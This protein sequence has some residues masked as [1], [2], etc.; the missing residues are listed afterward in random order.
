MTICYVVSNL[1]A[2]WTAHFDTVPMDTGN[3]WESPSQ[4]ETGTMVSGVRETGWADFT[5][6]TD[7]GSSVNFRR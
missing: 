4:G 3:P 5:A 6:F 7:F 1:P 2:T